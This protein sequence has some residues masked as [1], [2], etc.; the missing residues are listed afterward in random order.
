MTSLELAKAFQV[1]YNETVENQKEQIR[2]AFLD[3]L[4]NIKD[5]IPS[6]IGSYNYDFVLK[7]N[8][9][10]QFVCL[11]YVSEWAYLYFDEMENVEVESILTGYS[12][13][14]KADITKIELKIS[15]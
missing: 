2:M 7:V 8:I 6:M 10:V 3:E 15:V 12:Y 14:D 4:E 11:E 1:E 13:S 9:V 5:D